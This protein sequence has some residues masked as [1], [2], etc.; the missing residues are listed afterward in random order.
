MTSVSSRES[1]LLARECV[2]EVI[3]QCGAQDSVCPQDA[4]LVVLSRITVNA[5]DCVL[6]AQVFHYDSLLQ[7]VDEAIESYSESNIAKFAYAF[8]ILMNEMNGSIIGAKEQSQLAV[9]DDSTLDPVYQVKEEMEEVVAGETAAIPLDPAS[10]ESMFPTEVKTEIKLELEEEEKP[11]G[12]IEE[13]AIDMT[14]MESHDT[15][16]TDA[17]PVN[18]V[19]RSA[20][21]TIGPVGGRSNR[22][23]EDAFHCHPGPSSAAAL[24]PEERSAWLKQAMKE[25]V[26]EKYGRRRAAK[27]PALFTVPDLPDTVS[28]RVSGR[29]HVCRDTV[30]DIDMHVRQFH[31]R[32]LDVIRK[33]PAKEVPS[34]TTL[35]KPVE[36]DVDAGPCANPAWRCE[37][38]PA[39]VEEIELHEEQFHT[40]EW[41]KRAGTCRVG[42]CDYR[43]INPTALKEHASIAHSNVP[44]TASL[45]AS[46]PSKTRCP[47]CQTY[48][49]G[50]PFLKSHMR[51]HQIM[52]TNQTP[53]L[54]CVACSFKCARVYQMI[55][56]W[57]ESRG[58]CWKGLR[59]DYAAAKSALQ[60]AYWAAP[61]ARR[62]SRQL[63]TAAAA[64]AA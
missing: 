31:P 20:P 8:S 61:A 46:F 13:P 53:I 7:S 63:P 39:V 64:A 55:R 5:L 21:D 43:S 22:R 19:V 25:Q 60:H 11:L 36:P 62:P 15:E 14:E 6:S 59:F 45:Y 17:V 37:L 50:L 30:D 34:S 48:V 10:L 44:A 54:I 40:E 51:I 41:L 56:H 2:T 33:K 49:P 42:G 9:V 18:G 29:C 35:P 4:I 58:A 47:Y 27:V 28:E 12:L 1:I 38:C 16:G 24:T 26:F 57:S 52:L 23:E 3:E 32:R